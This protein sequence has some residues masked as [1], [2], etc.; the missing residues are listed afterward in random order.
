MD[1]FGTNTSSGGGTHPKLSL[2]APLCRPHPYRGDIALPATST[3]GF[4]SQPPFPNPPA[5]R[6][7]L[8]V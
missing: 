7:T 6:I 2:R 1:Q 8:D 5:M 4:D 3:Q